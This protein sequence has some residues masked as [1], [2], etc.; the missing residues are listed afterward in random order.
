MSMIISIFS[1]PNLRDGSSTLLSRLDD[2]A[3]GLNVVLCSLLRECAESE[4]IDSEWCW[5][6][7]WDIATAMRF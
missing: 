6:D 1:E 5:E 3:K 7:D 2:E 4:G